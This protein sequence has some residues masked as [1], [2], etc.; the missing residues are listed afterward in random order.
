M[1]WIKW[2]LGV[3][4]AGVITFVPTNFI[5]HRTWKVHMDNLATFQYS[6]QSLAVPSLAF[7][8]FLF[9]SCVFVP[10]QKKQGFWFFYW[11]SFLFL[12]GHINI[13]CNDGILRNQYDDAILRNQYIVRYSRFVICLVIGFLVSHKLF[14][15]TN[16]AS[17]GQKASR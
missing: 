12:W 15:Q 5:M 7:G 11:P 10:I 1:K 3:V 4:T 17:N 6:V 16:W 9:L 13:T 8:L 2:I 14:R